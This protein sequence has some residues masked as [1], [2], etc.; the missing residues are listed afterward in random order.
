MYSNEIVNATI[1]VQ[2]NYADI[3]INEIWSNIRTDIDDGRDEPKELSVVEALKH[4]SFLGEIDINSVAESTGREVV[5]VQNAIIGLAFPNPELHKEGNSFGWELAEDYISGNLNRKLMI[6]EAAEIKFPGMFKAHIQ[7][8]KKAMTEIFDDGDY[9]ITLGHPLPTK[10][11]DDFIHDLLDVP[12]HLRYYETR[13]DDIIGKWEIGSKWRFRENI[14]NVHVYGTDRMSAVEIIERQLNMKEIKVTDLVSS[15]STKSGATYVINAEETA[16]AQDKLCR[17]LAKFD[18]WLWSNSKWSHHAKKLMNDKFNCIINRKYD[19]DRFSFTGLSEAVVP[20]KYEKDFAA[21]IILR[22]GCTLLA[23]DTGAGKTFIMIMAI[24]ELV[25]LGLAHKCMVTVPNDIVGQW[26]DTFKMLY[27][28]SNVF[29]VTPRDFNTSNKSE[30]LRKIRDG[31]YDAVL[32]PHSCFDRI[33]LSR[34]HYVEAASE[35]RDR[36][37]ASKKPLSTGALKRRIEKAEKEL[38]KTAVSHDASCESICFDEL[39]IDRLFVDEGHLYKNVSVDTSIL[40]P[41]I[42]KKGSAKCDALMHKIRHVQKKNKGGGVVIA[43]ATPISNSLTDLYI[44]QKYLQPGELNFLDLQTF[45]A[46]IATFAEKDRTPE[47]N[48]VTD[49]YRMTTRFSKFHN[50][51]QLTN[52]LSSVALF[53]HIENDEDVPIFNGYKDVVIPKSAAVSEY[54][55]SLSKRA[56]KVHQHLVKPKEDNMLKITTDGRKAALDIRL[57]RPQITNLGM[58][59]VGECAER[60][61]LVYHRTRESQSTQLVYCDI[62]TPKKGEFTIYDELKRLLVYLGVNAEEVAFI[63][64]AKTTAQKDKLFRQFREGKVRILIGSTGKLGTGVNLQNKVIAMH[65]LDIPWKPSDLAQREGRGIRR[66]NENSEIEIYRYIQQGSFDAYSWQLLEIK[67][68]FISDLL[69]GTK[70]AASGADVDETVLSYAEVKAIAL[71]NI[72]L[73][74]RA[75]L[76]NEITRLR[77]VQRKTYEDRIRMEKKLVELPRIIDEKDKIYREYLADARYVQSVNRKKSQKKSKYTKKAATERRYK[78]KD[79]LYKGVINNTMKT[80]ERALMKYRGFDVSLPKYMEEE[81]PYIY[82]SRSHKYI[83]EMGS[84]DVGMLVRLDNFI[85][86]I[87]DHADRMRNTIDE[88]RKEESDIKKELLKE[89]NYTEQIEAC[90]EELTELD[91]RLGIINGY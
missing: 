10:L 39:G 75:K 84:N 7:A 29:V 17:I 21:A 47:I 63:H 34:K 83:V 42:N 73:K 77:M 40:A 36:L 71:G 41:N 61:A 22:K 82:I 52:L 85:D 56:D 27:P 87:S 4:F 43:T 32:I 51:P 2:N 72:E 5:E 53:H 81:S 30:T 14:L 3:D 24:M 64:D 65:H 44:F 66:G 50:I 54:I 74:K 48:V 9:Y 86:H 6:A 90:R 62:S 23:L 38:G 18:S 16:A 57:V 31:I 8:L 11:I 88:L 49:S 20:Y 19:G 35:E 13:H 28:E 1:N 37:V 76:Q 46:W 25:R 45:D 79:K 60:V 89:Y 68:R 26:R 33:P 12:K 80:E 58:T 70:A 59:K 15:S 91:E 78:I 69:S 55:Q 67:Q